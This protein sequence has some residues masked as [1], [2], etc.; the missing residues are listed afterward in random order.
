MSTKSKNWMLFVLTVVVVFLLGLLAS[1]ITNRKAEA[2]FAYM[3]KIEI[4]QNES[5]NSV[6]G[7]YFPREYQSFLKTKDTSFASYNNKDGYKDM[8]EDSPRLVVFAQHKRNCFRPERVTY[9]HIRLSRE[10]EIFLLLSW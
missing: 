7:E 8:L 10:S 1:N 6:W 3:P 2:R 4:D 9:T 5:D